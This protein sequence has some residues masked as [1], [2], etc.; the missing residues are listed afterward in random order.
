MNK[1]CHFYAGFS[2]D[3]FCMLIQILVSHTIRATGL[4][5]LLHYVIIGVLL[6][7]CLLKDEYWSRS[8]LTHKP[9]CVQTVH[10]HKP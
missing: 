10:R 9:P 6:D 4:W 3:N 7:F 5:G 2:I 8:F 1:L